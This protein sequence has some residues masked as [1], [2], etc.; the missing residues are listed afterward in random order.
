MFANS[1][2]LVE[3]NQI[4]EDKPCTLVIVQILL[5]FECATH[6]T[7]FVHEIVSR[8]SETKR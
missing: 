8:S 6:H 3:A 2:W 7:Y 4:P 1:R 5:P